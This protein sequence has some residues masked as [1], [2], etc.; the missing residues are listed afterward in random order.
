MLGGFFGLES[1][2]AL[3]IIDE[4]YK[5]LRDLAF[6]LGGE[7]LGCVVESRFPTKNMTSELLYI[8]ADDDGESSQA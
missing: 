8:V 7:T 3:G 4:G 6:L 2:G 1:C 5:V